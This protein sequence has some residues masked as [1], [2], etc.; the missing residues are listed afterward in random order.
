[1]KLMKFAAAALLSTV[2]ATSAFAHATLEQQQAE[3]GT[4]YKGVMRIP[5]GCGDEATLK[6]R[7]QIPEGVISVKP[8][9]K[10]GW[11]L[12]TV[13]SD[14]AKSYEYY[15]RTLTE[16]VTEI[17]WT[18][19][20]QSDHYDEFTFRGKLDKSLEAGSTLHF[21]TIQECATGNRSWITIPAEGQD[22][23]DVKDPAPGLKLIEGHAHH[24]H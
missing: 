13:K 9:P 20:L 3:V 16:G 14:Y 10:A 4:T 8:M 23:H 12:E 11:A 1:M 2:A 6:L 22:P 5:H 15:G 21:P 19:E 7:I 24:G 18:G 17:I